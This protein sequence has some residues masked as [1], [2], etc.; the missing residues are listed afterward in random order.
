VTC[1]GLARTHQTDTGHALLA[2][3]LPLFVCC[4]GGILLLIMFGGIAALSQHH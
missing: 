3:L 4:G 1:V 2:V